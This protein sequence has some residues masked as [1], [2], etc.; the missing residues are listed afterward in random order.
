MAGHGA[1]TKETFETGVIGHSAGFYVDL[2]AQATKE[3]IVLVEGVVSNIQAAVKLYVLP[4]GSHQLCPGLADMPHDNVPYQKQVID[5]EDSM[6]NR[7]KEWL[8]S[9]S[10]NEAPFKEVPFKEFP[11]RALC[12]LGTLA[13]LAAVLSGSLLYER[14]RPYLSELDRVGLNWE[15]IAVGIPFGVV[16]LIF[17]VTSACAKRFGEI[18][19]KRLLD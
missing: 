6:I 19:Y 11:S 10:L 2:A 15:T 16:G 7:L 1:D 9:K 13:Y 3:S 14:G 8:T 4:H 18:L 5:G 17:L 12:A